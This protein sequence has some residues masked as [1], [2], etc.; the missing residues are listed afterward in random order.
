M[1]SPFPGMDPYI[2]DPEVWNDFHNRIADEISAR[3]NNT[4]QPRYVARLIPYVTYEA[5]SV[6]ARPQ[7]IRPDIGIW[8][9][10]PPR[11]SVGCESVTRPSRLRVTDPH[12]A[13]PYPFTEPK[14][15]QR[16][17]SAASWGTKP[18]TARACARSR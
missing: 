7:G 6:M 14:P 18:T 15:N 9:P 10:Q 2:E 8:Q 12:S 5:V 1:P 13:I 11:D 16:Y 3:L 17:A 4:I